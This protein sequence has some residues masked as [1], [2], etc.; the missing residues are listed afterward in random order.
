MFDVLAKK[1]EF[2]A[3]LKEI[4]DLFREMSS[5]PSRSLRHEAIKYIYTKQMKEGTSVRECVLDMMM[6]FNIIKVN[7]GPINEENQVS[8]ILQ[9][10]PKNFVPFQM[11][12]S[13]NKIEFTLTTLLNEP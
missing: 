9:P 1:H 5:Q 2:V 4:V 7:G 8:F 10:L 12:T 13:L 3:T 11:N 6:H